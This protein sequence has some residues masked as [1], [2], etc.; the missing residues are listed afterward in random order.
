MLVIRKWL[1][2]KFWVAANDRLSSKLEKVSYNLKCR[3]SFL[4]L[5]QTFSNLF[6]IAEILH[7]LKTLKSS[8]YWLIWCEASV[9]HLTSNL[10]LVFLCCIQLTFSFGVNISFVWIIKNKSSECFFWA[11]FHGQCLGTSVLG[12]QW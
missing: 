11:S 10:L 4:F 8:L 9:I 2:P 1:T 6:C 12:P 3:T 7:L 5:Y